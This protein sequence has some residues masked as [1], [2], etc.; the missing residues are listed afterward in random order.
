MR[1]MYCIYDKKAESIV[2]GIILERVD[3]PA[4]RAFHDALNPKN[5]TVLSEH[6]EDFELWLL[7][8]LDD[9]GELVPN[10]GYKSVATGVQWAAANTISQ[11][12]AR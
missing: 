8:A 3:A 6:P 4:I 11:E 10:S 2:G 7:G 1:N 5:G 9:Q 12:I